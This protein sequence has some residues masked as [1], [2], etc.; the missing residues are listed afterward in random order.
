MPFDRMK[1]T[2]LSFL[3]SDF[4]TGL[5]RSTGIRRAILLRTFTDDFLGSRF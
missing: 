1:S 4:G 3:R 5:L 2:F